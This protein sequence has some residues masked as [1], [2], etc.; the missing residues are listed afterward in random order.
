MNAKSVLQWSLVFLL[1]G[2]STTQPVGQV[3]LCILASCNASPV[4]DRVGN[5]QATGATITEA[6]DQTNRSAQRA[7]NDASVSGI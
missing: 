2:C 1:A 6:V 4:A 7:D 3:Q 5:P